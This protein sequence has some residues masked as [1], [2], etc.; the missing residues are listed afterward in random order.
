MRHRST[1]RGYRITVFGEDGTWGF[2]I[3]PI[4]P[5]LPIVGHGGGRRFQSEEEALGEA[6]F[7]VDALLEL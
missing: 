6:K 2:A 4:S 7:R 3:E 1:Y 5:D